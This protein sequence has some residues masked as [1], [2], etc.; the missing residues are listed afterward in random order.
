MRR[1]DE[2]APAPGGGAS[3]LLKSTEKQHGLPQSLRSRARHLALLG[4]YSR[5]AHRFGRDMPVTDVMRWLCNDPLR[6]SRARSIAEAA[7]SERGRLDGMLE[8]AITGW[9][10]DRLGAVERAGLRAAA[11]EI[12]VLRDAPAGAVINDHVELARRYGEEASP[13]FVNAVLS[14]FLAREDVTATL[15]R[16]PAD[17]CG[18]DLHTH[19]DWS[20]GELSPEALVAAAAAAGLTAL[21]VADHDEVM[22]VAAAVEAGRAAGVEVVPAVELT[23]YL[24]DAEFHILGLLIDP[25]DRGLTAA[26]GRFRQGRVERAAEMCK[27]MTTQGFPVSVD[28]VCELAGRGAVGRPHLAKALVEAGHAGSFQDAFRRFIGNSCP[29]YVPKVH[30]S[31]AEAMGLIHGA[32]GLAML[33]HPGSSGR[34][35]LFPALVE[36]GLDGMEARHSLH[37]EP[38]AANYERWA[39][40]RD[41]LVSGGSDFHGNNIDA[42]PLGKPFVPETWLTALRSSWRLRKP[43]AAAS[44]APPS[45]PVVPAAGG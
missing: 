13:G 31:P 10:L 29:A 26:L 30:L 16:R 32:G 27:R 28:R 24:G 7:L 8:E 4:L 19:T 2:P 40:R 21:A 25:A 3:D 6:R 18:V 20:D 1:I 43:E 35:E 41:L 17:E 39:Y 11:A 5:E 36:A 22:G 15:A 37:S 9:K 23:S 14:Q 45:A 42:R 33:A 34:E 44:S 38:T 12:V